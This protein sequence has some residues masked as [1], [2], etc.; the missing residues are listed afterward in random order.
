MKESGN[1]KKEYYKHYY[2]DFNGYSRYDP[3]WKRYFEN[4]LLTE[5]AYIIRKFFKLDVIK[6]YYQEHLTYTM[7]HR[8]K[9]VYLLSLEM[10]FRV[11]LK[12]DDL[13]VVKS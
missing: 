5:D 2:S 1:K 12:D 11:F 8:K 6:K 7:N 13:M 3:T 4:Y 10:F 9:I